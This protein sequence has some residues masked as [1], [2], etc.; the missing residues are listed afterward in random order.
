M[1]NQEKLSIKRVSLRDRVVVC[2]L[3][4]GQV[5]EVSESHH[6]FR[7]N[8]DPSFFPKFMITTDETMSFSVFIFNPNSKLRFYCVF[9]PLIY[10]DI[11][12][13]L[14]QLVKYLLGLTAV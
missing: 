7:S 8:L 3:I 13:M 12:I 6:F 14:S 4:L 5:R 10:S 9:T 1:N 11:K 2:K